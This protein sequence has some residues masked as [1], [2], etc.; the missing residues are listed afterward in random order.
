M[1]YNKL[2]GYTLHAS[3]YKRDADINF[4]SHYP[5]AGIVRDNRG[6]DPALPSNIPL[7]G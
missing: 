6:F 5:C 2:S 7:L 4:K 1:C 3:N